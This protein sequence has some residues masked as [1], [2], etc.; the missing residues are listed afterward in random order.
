VHVY[1]IQYTEGYVTMWEVIPNSRWRAP[2]YIRELVWCTHYLMSSDCMCIMSVTFN[3]W[4]P[5]LIVPYKSFPFPVF[6][7]PV[8]Q[9]VP[10]I[11]TVERKVPVPVDRPY[12]VPVERKVPVAY[13]VH[14]RWRVIEYKTE[15]NSSYKYIST[16]IIRKKWLQ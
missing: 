4:I 2:T 7:V 16:R 15:Q 5:Y 9:K 1:S 14:G 13:P 10:V 6:S 11:Q 8:V 3:M 12:P